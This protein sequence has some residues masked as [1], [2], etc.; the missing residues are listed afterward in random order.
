MEGKRENGTGLGQRTAL[1][2]RLPVGDGLAETQRVRRDPPKN[3]VRGE[4]GSSISLWKAPESL[5][6]SGV[7]SLLCVHHGVSG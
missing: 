6:S 5:T 7:C 4:P 2:Y 1:F 3:G